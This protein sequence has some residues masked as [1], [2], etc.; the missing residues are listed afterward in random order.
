MKQLWQGL[1]GG[2]LLSTLA[3]PW[4]QAASSENTFLHLLKQIQPGAQY[5]WLNPIIG[6]LVCGLIAAF[7]WFGPKLIGAVAE[8]L[9]KKG[10]AVLWALP[11]LA[12]CQYM[13][14]LP[15]L[16]EVNMLAENA[17][18]SMGMVS[19]M[20]TL[21]SALFLTALEDSYPETFAGIWRGMSLGMPSEMAHSFWSGVYFYILALAVP[22]FLTSMAAAVSFGVFVSIALHHL[23]KKIRGAP[24]TSLRQHGNRRLATFAGHVVLAVLCLTGVPGYS[25]SGEALSIV[26]Q[27]YL[28]GVMSF[29]W[30]ALCEDS[31]EYENSEPKPNW[32]LVFSISS[33]MLGCLA[34]LGLGGV[35]A[36]TGYL[37]AAAVLGLTGLLTA[38]A[39]RPSRHVTG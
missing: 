32:D 12:A 1:A 8:N 27:L 20:A 4:A 25:Y 21:F 7:F 17:F 22:S 30:L 16:S 3:S 37:W 33:P 10:L 18:E 14:F 19:L 28:A 23:S 5:S 9:R 6:L 11:L 29:C 39:S 26:L 38:L 35:L 13:A 31:Y 24:A 34:W 36:V 15:I 2:A